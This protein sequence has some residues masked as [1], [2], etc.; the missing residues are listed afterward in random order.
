MMR[1]I[2]RT[3][4]PRILRDQ[5]VVLLVSF[6]VALGTTIRTKCEH[7]TASATILRSGP[8]ASVS[9]ASGSFYSVLWFL[10]GGHWGYPSWRARKSSTD[11]YVAKG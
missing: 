9:V 11:E 3:D 5:V 4:L 1:N 2:M 8:T 7:R 10:I 6:A